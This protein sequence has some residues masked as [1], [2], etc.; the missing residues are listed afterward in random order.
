LRG[1][2]LIFTLAVQQDK[3][4]RRKKP[5]DFGRLLLFMLGGGKYEDCYARNFFVLSLLLSLLLSCHTPACA[6]FIF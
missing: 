1:K 4:Y 5:A 2:F 6:L 3:T